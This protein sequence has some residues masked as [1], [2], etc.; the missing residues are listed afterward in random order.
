M[1]ASCSR[2]EGKFCAWW[3]HAVAFFFNFFKFLLIGLLLHFEF[4]V[5]GGSRVFAVLIASKYLN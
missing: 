4:S 3:S 1:S 5:G 2:E